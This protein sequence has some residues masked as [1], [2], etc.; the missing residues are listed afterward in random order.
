V[1]PRSALVTTCAG[2]GIERTSPFGERRIRL[3][4][5]LRNVGLD[6]APKFDVRLSII[7]KFEE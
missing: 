7:R 6:S 1:S 2:S 5:G 3:S 4:L